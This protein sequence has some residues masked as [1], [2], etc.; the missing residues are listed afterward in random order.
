MTSLYYHKK[1]F[2]VA[3]AIETLYIYHSMIEKMQFLAQQILRSGF[4]IESGSYLQ[5]SP[6]AGKLSPPKEYEQLMQVLDKIE[7]V[8]I[9]V[10]GIEEGLVDFPHLRTTGEE[11]YLCF[12]VGEETIQFWHP[13]DTGFAGRQPLNK[14]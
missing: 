11:V 2:T 3:E 7:S 5:N 4:N 12:Q 10:K 13:I 6:N 8:G 9:V 1:H 14:L